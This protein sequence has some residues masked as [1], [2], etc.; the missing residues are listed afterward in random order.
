MRSEIGVEEGEIIFKGG[1]APSEAVSGRA[2]YTTVAAILYAGLA[3]GVLGEEECLWRGVSVDDVI[4]YC[5]HDCVVTVIERSKPVV[6]KKRG[7][8]GSVQVRH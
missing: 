5:T 8:C 6:D 1:N 7:P 4:R 3:A 2:T